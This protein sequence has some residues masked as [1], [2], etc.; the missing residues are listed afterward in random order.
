MSGCKK[1]LG[2]KGGIL[3]FGGGSID[4]CVFPATVFFGKTLKM[5]VL[6]CGKVLLSP[7]QS[8][9]SGGVK[10]KP[11]SASS[12]SGVGGGICSI[13]LWC[14]WGGGSDFYASLSPPPDGRGRRGGREN[15]FSYIAE[16]GERIKPLRTTLLAG[17]VTQRLRQE[18]SE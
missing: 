5:Q 7:F 9:F 17:K 15:P 10:S 8:L 12:A 4:N 16:G 18:K 11:F 14:A 3:L 2:G 6:L 13:P 1:G